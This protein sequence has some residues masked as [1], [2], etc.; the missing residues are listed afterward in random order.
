MCTKNKIQCISWA[1]AG[2]KW[3]EKVKTL[4]ISFKYWPNLKIIWHKC[5]MGEP[6]QRLLN[7][8]LIRWKKHG[9]QDV[10][11]ICLL[12]CIFKLKNLFIQIN[13]RDYKIIW[14][15]WCLGDYQDSSDCCDPLKNCCRDI[16]EFMLKTSLNPNKTKQTH[17]KVYILSLRRQFCSRRL[18]TYFV[19][20]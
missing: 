15:K 12:L 13:W 9:L 3:G 16:S 17:V 10:E 4:K 1:D 11:L 5:S 18:W 19:K 2:S 20:K 14:F 6:L 8:C 7:F